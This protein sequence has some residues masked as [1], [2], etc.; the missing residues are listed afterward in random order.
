MT[1]PITSEAKEEE[2]AANSQ[3]INA[4]H[5]V[6]EDET[7]D[8]ASQP[9]KIAR[10]AAVLL[11][12]WVKMPENFPMIA[13]FSLTIHE[14]FK[15]CL[16]HLNIGSINRHKLWRSFF[17]VR[18]SEEFTK[19]WKDFLS[20]ANV[21]ETPTLYQ[22]L[23]TLMFNEEVTKAIKME[24]KS[25]HAIEPLNDN[26]KNALR[27]T[28]GYICRHLRK[29]LE[30]SSHEMKEELV[31]CLMEMTTKKDPTALNTDEE[32]TVRVDRGGLWYVKNTTYLLFV[33]IEE[34]VRRCLKQLLTGSGLKSAIIK[35]TVESDDVTFY[36]LICQADF[37]VGDDETYKLLLNKIVELF[38]TMRGF[39]YASK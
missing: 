21:N 3:L 15:R 9:A 19:L 23:T 33:A 30:C 13:N 10:E 35:R 29:Q 14:Q 5:K 8:F 24:T 16:K 1:D 20:K 11:L 38:V 27:Y 26:E 18:S 22:H 4:L 25:P 7:F 32:W 31:L 2:S 37:D 6:L 28:A 34:E 36:W 12:D 39:F 17:C